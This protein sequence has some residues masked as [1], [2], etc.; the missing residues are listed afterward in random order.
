MFS[1]L[2]AL[3][4]WASTRSSKTVKQPVLF[5]CPCMILARAWASHAHRA[6]QISF[7]PSLPDVSFQRGFLIYLKKGWFTGEKVPF[8]W[9]TI[10]P[11]NF[12]TFY[13]LL[14]LVP[15]G[16]VPFLSF[17]DLR[18]DGIVLNICSLRST[19]YK[20]IVPHTHNWLSNGLP[21][22]PKR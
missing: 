11:A 18:W 3:K 6:W 19:S 8:L 17:F 16:S 10:Y 7:S 21:K 5:L 15:S 2:L 9:S 22:W 4:L 1:N 12:D 14:E 13:G 20:I